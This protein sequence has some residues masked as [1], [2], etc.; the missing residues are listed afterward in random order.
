MLTVTETAKAH[1]GKLLEHTDAEDESCI[2]LRSD[3]K[4]LNMLMSKV[5]PDDVVF[6]HAGETVLV[7]D[8]PLAEMLSERTMDT[9]R[10][11]EGTRLTIV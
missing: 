8:K 1:L 5:E 6:Q 3:G 2:R 9:T 7:V 10:T 11:Q 4:V